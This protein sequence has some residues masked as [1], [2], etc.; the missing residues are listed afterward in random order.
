[1][2]VKVCKGCG[3]PKSLDE[4]SHN[5]SKKDGREFHCKLCKRSQ[6]NARYKAGGEQTR[7][8][9]REWSIKWARINRRRARECGRESYYRDVEYTRLKRRANMAVW[10]ARQR[11]VLVKPNNCEGCETPELECNGGK[12][13]AHHYLGYARE[14]QLN[15]QWFC[16][17]CHK[18]ADL[19]LAA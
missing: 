12:L 9:H 15:V 18:Q 14:H 6:N 1:M 13:E 8:A 16:T 10:R 2:K 4:F 19:A 11:G 7:A 5:R 3:V 17:V